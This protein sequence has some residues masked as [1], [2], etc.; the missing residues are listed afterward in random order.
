MFFDAIQ[1]FTS[2]T[3]AKHW[4]KVK[5]FSKR[6]DDTKN[7]VKLEN[8]N[9][10]EWMVFHLSQTGIRP[11]FSQ[12]QSNTDRLKPEKLNELRSISGAVN[13]M[14]WIIAKLAQLLLLFKPPPRAPFFGNGGKS[15]MKRS[16]K[17]TIA[18]GILVELAHCN[19]LPIYKVFMTRIELVWALCCTN[20]RKLTKA[21]QYNSRPIF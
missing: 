10:T 5:N 8:I 18:V 11:L 9:F 16:P 17:R 7:P 6:L 13:Q 3:K 1:D 4:E 12:K 2:C 14:N 19:A 21:N 15:T 20:G